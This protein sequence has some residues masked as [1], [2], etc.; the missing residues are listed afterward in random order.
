[1]KA[2]LSKNT[3]VTIAVSREISVNIAR[4]ASGFAYFD[5]AAHDYGLSIYAC[6]RG[7]ARY[8]MTLPSR[9]SASATSMLGAPL[10]INAA[11]AALISRAA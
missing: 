2:T 3:A 7:F 10:L 8:S 4:R 5:D 6:T 9:L 11:A 1:M